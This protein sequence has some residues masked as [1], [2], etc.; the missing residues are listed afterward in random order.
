MPEK[1]VNS[2]VNTRNTSSKVGSIPPGDFSP[3]ARSDPGR[4]NGPKF[5]SVPAQASNARVGRNTEEPA[6]LRIHGPE[7]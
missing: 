5:D 7:A 6:E 2:P 1:D 3:G 4:P